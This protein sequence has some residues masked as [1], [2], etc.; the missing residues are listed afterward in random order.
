MS[1]IVSLRLRFFVWNED[2]CGLLL[3]VERLSGL[4]LSGSEDQGPPFGIFAMK[5]DGDTSR[6]EEGHHSS[7]SLDI[8]SASSS[9]NLI[10]SK[11][12]FVETKQ[13]N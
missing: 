8:L 7:S 11:D 9:M 4:S 5:G 2:A 1:A 13:Y 12:G 3:A 6:L 10:S